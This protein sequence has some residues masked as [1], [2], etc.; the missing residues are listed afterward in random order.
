[1]IVTT[2]RAEEVDCPVCETLV[3]IKVLM[4]TNTFGGQDTDFRTHAAGY[5]PLHIAISICPTCGFS[6]FELAFKQPPSLDPS[7]KSRIRDTLKPEADERGRI[8]TS[9]KYANAARIALWHTQPLENVADLFLRAAW[10]CA[11]ERDADGERTY[12]L[13]AIEHFEQ[14]LDKSALQI[15]NRY[16]LEYLIAELYRRIGDAETANARFDELIETLNK[17]GVPAEVKWLPE[18]VVRQRY[19]P[20]NT[21][22]GDE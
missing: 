6:G 20:K 8:R 13:A 2:F 19:E 4:T 18:I 3:E 5:D 22:K 7:Q 16:A 1:M 11:D 14:A 12:R 9:V 10:C 15:E 21:F 17:V